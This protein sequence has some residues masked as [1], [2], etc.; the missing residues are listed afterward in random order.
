MP[1]VNI[2]ITREGS[3]PGR[4]AA[5]A[6]EKAQLI[7]GVSELLLNILRKPLDG[8]FVTIEEVEMEN[9]GWGGLPVEEFRRVRNA[10]ASET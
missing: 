6:D 5:T 10:A 2:T 7:K 8:T 4:P 3:A 9:F 1:I